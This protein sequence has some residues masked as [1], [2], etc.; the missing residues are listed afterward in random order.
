MLLLSQNLHQILAVRNLI[1]EFSN[2]STFCPLTIV[3]LPCAWLWFFFLYTFSTRVQNIQLLVQ[4]ILTIMVKF[5]QSTAISN[6]LDLMS[7]LVD[8]PSNQQW[9]KMISL[10]NMDPVKVG[11]KLHHNITCC[12]RTLLSPSNVDW[13]SYSPFNWPIRFSVFKPWPPQA[14]LHSWFNL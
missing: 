10:Q 7:V 9:N 12:I 8:E 2:Y 13:T 3:P 1:F 4:N 6:I 5:S 11:R 14:S